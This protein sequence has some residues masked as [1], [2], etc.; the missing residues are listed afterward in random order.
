MRSARAVL[1][2]TLAAGLATG[3]VACGASASAGDQVR[4]KVRQFATATDARNVDVLCTQVLA[5]A[6]VARLTAA[7]LSCPQ[8][9]HLFVTSVSHPTIS[10]S[11]VTVHGDSASAVVLA[12]ASGQT[13]ALESIQLVRT[14]AG[15]R[16][17]SLASPR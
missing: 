7:G 10:I 4:A 12:G 17:A 5:P 6:L 2:V 1:T 13:S 16:L 15:W 3:L 9:M 8:A 14:K 11:K